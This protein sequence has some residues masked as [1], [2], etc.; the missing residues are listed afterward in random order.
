[1]PT[2]NS[3]DVFIAGYLKDELKVLN[4]HL[5][6]KRKSLTEL[7]KEEHPYVIC[8][9]GNAHFFKKKELEYLSKMLDYDEQDSLLL[10]IIMEVTPDQSWVT[11]RSK[12]GVEAKIFSK[13]LG[14]TVVSKH[15]ITTIF[16]SQMSVVR[17]ALKTATQYVFY[18]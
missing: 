14:I 5:P 6:R 11:I 12:G 9:D 3:S 16:K 1:M 17:K 2:D 10:P 8:N 4:A 15:N 18:P 7:L 13:I